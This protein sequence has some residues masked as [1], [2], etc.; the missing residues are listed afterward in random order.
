MAYCHPV[1]RH[2]PSIPSPKLLVLPVNNNVN[3]AAGAMYSKIFPVN[4]QSSHFIT[5]DLG[6]PP[7]TIRL[8][9]DTSYRGL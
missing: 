5:L 7:Q 4:P 3:N 9:L 2:A 8:T 1:Y 6:T